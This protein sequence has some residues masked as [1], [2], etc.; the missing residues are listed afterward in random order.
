M[1]IY[2]VPRGFAVFGLGLLTIAVRADEVRLED[3]SVLFGTVT[4]LD[5]D[6]SLRVNSPIAPNPL[7]IRA[8]KIE[9]V[10]FSHS[11]TTPMEH[12]A[13]VVLSNGD[14]LS[15]DVTRIEESMVGVRSRTV[16]ELRIP[17]QQVSQ[18]QLGVRPRKLVYQGPKD[19]LNWKFDDA[20]HLENGELVSA[21]QGGAWSDFGEIPENFS[22]SFDLIWAHS[23]NLQV[24]FCTTSDQIGRGRTERYTLE[25]KA[26]EIELKRQV[27]EDA[28]LFSLGTMEMPNQRLDVARSPVAPVT[29][30][31]RVDRSLNY[32][33]VFLDGVRVGSFHDPIPEVASG[34][35]IIFLSRLKSE[36]GH[37]IRNIRIHEWDASGDRHQSEDRGKVDGDAVIDHDGQRFSGTLLRSEVGENGLNLLFKSPHF[38]E[39]FEIPMGRVCTLFMK[40]AH[41]E[42]PEG[43]LR[44][45][46]LNESSLSAIGCQFQEA[47]VVLVHPFLGDLTIPRE[48]VVS[49]E[50][51]SA[52]EVQP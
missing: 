23:P 32:L 41:T 33:Q 35:G 7:S 8:D 44:L 34:N 12:D 42:K 52:Q 21:G 36:E 22:L 20:W 40:E 3:G 26:D 13:R 5:A 15:C 49:L 9:N 17:R 27:A 38:P 45:R 11:E 18:I 14:V 48:D 2:S 43:T 28:K 6:Q 29:V 4:H 46:T 30:E 19:A 31:I 37:R 50:K 39:P 25:I 24:Y 10:I 1:M 16:G 47:S 51:Q